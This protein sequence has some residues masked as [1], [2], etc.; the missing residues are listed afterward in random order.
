MLNTTFELLRKANA[1]KTRYRYLAKELGGIKT[2]GRD[3]Q[4]TLLQILDVCGLDDALWAMSAVSEEQYTERD[5]IARL[6]ACDCAERVL[7]LFEEKYPEDNRPRVAIKTARRYAMGQATEAERSAAG[8]A[9]REA[10]RIAAWGAEVEAWAAERIA[11]VAA[12]AAAA[13]SAEAAA[14]AAAEAAAAAARSAEWSAA[15]AAAYATVAAEEA[16][17]QWQEARLRKYLMNEEE[18]L[19]RNLADLLNRWRETARVYVSI[20]GGSDMKNQAIGYK[21]CIH[22]LEAILNGDLY[23]IEEGDKR[24]I[25]GEG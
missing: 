13:R 24:A 20:I 22:E 21:E 12:E 4:I 2:Y 14:A 6:F 15:A 11:A 7:P 25:E 5:K 18:T 17:R 16:E 3:T 23:P 8:E 19:R 9:A 1:C 10:E